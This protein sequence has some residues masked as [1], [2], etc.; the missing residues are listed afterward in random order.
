MFNPIALRTAK[1]LWSCGPSECSGV[2]MSEGEWII[3]S[4][5]SIRERG[6]FNEAYV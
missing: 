4:L 1:T 3:D 2:K 5:N 6:Q